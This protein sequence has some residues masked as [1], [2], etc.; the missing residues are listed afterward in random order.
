MCMPYSHIETWCFKVWMSFLMNET[1]IKTIVYGPY[2]YPSCHNF[3]VVVK[4]TC[5]EYWVVRHPRYALQLKGLILL[6]FF[7]LFLFMISIRAFFS[8]L[9]NSQRIIN[10]WDTNIQSTYHAFVDTNVNW[11]YPDIVQCN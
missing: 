2:Q 9:T 5:W 7:F 6:A 4:L 3:L 10:V 1:H 11:L 8:R